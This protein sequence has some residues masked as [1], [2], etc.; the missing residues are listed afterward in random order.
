MEQ[1][2]SIPKYLRRLSWN[3]DSTSDDLSD[4]R[5]S[6]PYNFPDLEWIRA[7]EREV[8][9]RHAALS[10]FLEEHPFLIEAVSY[11][12]NYFVLNWNACLARSCW[13]DLPIPATS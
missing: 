8:Y 9:N 7:K 3:L 10:M 1:A 2:N 6:L 5:F 13:H 4:R 12:D 11:G